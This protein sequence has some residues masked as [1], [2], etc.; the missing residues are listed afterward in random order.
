MSARLAPRAAGVVAVAAAAVAVA[1]VLLSWNLP[2]YDAA[3]RLWW[4]AQLSFALTGTVLVARRPGNRV[5]WV[6]AGA[7][8]LALLQ[9][10]ASVYAEH[11]HARGVTS[12]PA[13]TAA[14]LA[15]W[16]GAPMITLF[17]VYL[18]LLY[19]TG[20][21]PSPRWRVLRDATAGFVVTASVALSLKPGPVE[22][23]PVHNPLGIAA[24]EGPLTWF[25][26]YGFVFLG[27]LGLAAVT[28]LVLRF[29]SV[30]GVERM[31]I[32]WLMLALALV[33]GYVLISSVGLE[34]VLGLEPI[35]LVDLVGIGTLFLVPASIAVAVLRYRLYEID[36]VVSRTVSWALI[37]ASLL[38]LYGAGVFA[39]TPLVAGVGGGSQLAVAASTL[40]VAAAFRP[41]RRRVQAGVDRRFDRGRYDARQVVDQ[42][43]ARLRDEV[44]LDELRSDLTGVVGAAVA[45][46]AV[47]VWLREPT[48]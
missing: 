42:F 17:L 18:P 30:E 37:T 16:L 23:M 12:L 26:D 7:G 45:P 48:P 31:Q 10:F 2:G 28:S 24:W 35:W 13:L 5:G 34:L 32:K 36:R 14:W 38:A 1:A 4:G 6:L 39:L 40:A 43:A 44:D 20:C 9:G 29:R 47:S 27:L 25:Y 19:P 8:L 15:G 46:V 3:A 33:L 21:L 22:G 11:S 41:V